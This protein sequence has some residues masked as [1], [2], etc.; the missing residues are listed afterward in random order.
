MPKAE[1][2]LQPR[3]NG[4]AYLLRHGRAPLCHYVTS[5]PAERGER[6]SGVFRGLL[7]GGGGGAEGDEDFEVALVEVAGDV[8]DADAAAEAVVGA[9][10]PLVAA[11]H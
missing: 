8:A 5:P 9:L 3:R 2:G 6:G 10:L 1:G 4:M 7:G 11:D